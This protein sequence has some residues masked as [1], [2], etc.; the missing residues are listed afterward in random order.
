MIASTRERAF[1]LTYR[2]E[3][4]SGGKVGRRCA[5]PETIRLCPN[6]V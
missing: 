2:P 1:R 5:V 6:G 3:I 4:E